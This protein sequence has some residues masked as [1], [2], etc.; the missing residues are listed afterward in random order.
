MKIRQGFVSNSSSSSFTCCVCGEEE[1]GWDL[2]YDTCERGHDLCGDCSIEADSPC[3]DCDEE[4]DDKCS[5]C[6]HHAD[7]EA[8]NEGCI[9][10]CCCPVCT[11]KAIA[12][13]EAALFLEKEHGVS[14]VLVFSIIKKGNPRRRKLY[15][16]E[17]VDYVLGTKLGLS[18]V[19]FLEQLKSRF[20]TY[21]KF[22][23]YMG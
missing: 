18:D 22:M 5:A 15:D 1:S 19:A 7:L 4:D 20:G 12:P 14:R 13:E 17:Y 21:Q 10:E 3:D 11:F 23:E 2:E 8:K 16:K 9:P 6:P